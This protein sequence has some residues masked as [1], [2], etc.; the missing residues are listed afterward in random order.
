MS[1]PKIV[2]VTGAATGIGAL[3]VRALARRGHRVYAGMR[4]LDGTDAAAAD[5][6]RSEAESGRLAMSALQMD[7]T[8][9]HDVES[10]VATVLA[11]QG[12]VDVVVHN[13]GH[14]ALGPAEA[15]TPE[16][17]QRLY[18][19]NVLG[20][21]RTNRAVL[22][23][24][25]RQGSGLLVWVSSSSTR[26]GHTPFISPYFAAKAAMDSLAVDYADELIRFGI[27]TCIVVPGAFT[28]G[29][30]HFDHA[31]H[32]GDGERATAY[33]EKYGTFMSDIRPRLA[34][35][36]PPGSDVSLVSERIAEVVDLPAGQRPFR[37]HVDPN[38]NGSEVV[39]A[40]ADRIRADFYR[41]L[42]IDDLL[43]DLSSL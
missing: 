10:A 35:L 7:V 26:G 14:M 8:S 39:S 3:S 2:I 22:P 40:V 30:R 25:R 9:D 23:H 16:D 18:D 19:I 4:S 27:E 20:A 13:A 41:R 28:S 12:R 33:D 38:R 31:D 32:P 29:T 43:P 15:F 1:E 24:L 34:A 37:T 11:E 6:L 36:A 42:G 21:H 5:E 17:F